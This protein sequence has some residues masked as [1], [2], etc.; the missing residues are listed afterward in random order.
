MGITRRFRLFLTLQAAILLAVGMILAPACCAGTLYE[1]SLKMMAALEQNTS[2]KGFTFVVLGDS[3]DNEVVFKKSLELAATFNPLFI[4]HDGDFSSNGTPQEVDHF[5]ETIRAIVPDIPLFVVKG[6]HERRQ[7]FQ[8]KIGPLNY[9]IDSAKLGFKLIVVDNSDYALKQA[10]S[11]FLKNNLDGTRKLAF[12]VMHI[13][14]KTKRWSWHT[15]SEGASGMVR[16]LSRE[17]VS[18]AFYGHLHLYD[19]D[20]LEGVPHIITGGAGAP[21]VSIGFPGDPVYHIV[22]VKIK[23]GTFQYGKVNIQK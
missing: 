20:E 21:L 17:K 15:F 11:D 1:R 23:N 13:P 5:L 7:P 9:V 6:N 22:V 8:E 12:V 4:I 19:K 3:R 18:A 14:P 2:A 16:L 10:Q